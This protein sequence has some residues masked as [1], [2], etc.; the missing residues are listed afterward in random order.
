MLVPVD[1]RRV[2]ITLHDP[3]ENAFREPTDTWG[4]PTGSVEV[5]FR[6][7]PPRL[8]GAAELW[9]QRVP[10]TR[11]SMRLA[12][13]GGTFDVAGQEFHLS[14][15]RFGLT[16]WQR[17]IEISNGRDRWLVIAAG[18]DT[19]EIRR[20]ADA[21]VVYQRRSF[22]SNRVDTTVTPTECVLIVVLTVTQ[23]IE[24]ATLSRFFQ[25]I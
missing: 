18:F 14:K 12:Y 21:R 19:V 9:G 22:R 3:S 23:A 16:R 10:R 4:F 2:N 5:A 25:F 8:D 24:G 17:R 20:G 13:R 7:G 6:V 15:A 11:F 1:Y